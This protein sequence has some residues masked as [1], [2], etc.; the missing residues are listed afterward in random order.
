MPR[1]GSSCALTCQAVLRRYF[2]KFLAA[3]T[4]GEASGQFTLLSKGMGTHRRAWR[5]GKFVDEYYKFTLAFSKQA[6][7]PATR[8]VT[9]MARLAMGLYLVH[10]NV[11]WFCDVK[12]LKTVDRKAWK[13]RAD[14]FRWLACVLN[15][16]LVAWKLLAGKRRV[17]KLEK[18][19]ERDGQ[20]VKVRQSNA[21]ALVDLARHSCDFVTYAN[22][23]KFIDQSDAVVGLLGAGSA[24]FAGF[25]VWRD[26][27]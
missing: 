12:M 27:L 18:D 24:V 7:D 8:G 25:G 19:D 17:A 16:V 15:L 10:D 5:L 1:V 3:V 21:N 6:M 11:I 4:A 23:S 9:L 22:S 26:K 20:L 14:R 2:G 13:L